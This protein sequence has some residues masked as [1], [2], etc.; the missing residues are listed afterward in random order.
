VKNINLL[1]RTP[2]LDFGIGSGQMTS[3]KEPLVVVI[4]KIFDGLSIL[5]FRKKARNP[6]GIYK[7]FKSGRFWP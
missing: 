4:Y 2:I 5:C 1:G 7:G 6:K 3:K